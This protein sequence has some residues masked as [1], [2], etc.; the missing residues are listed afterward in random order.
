MNLKCFK[1]WRTFVNNNKWISFQWT[2]DLLSV[3]IVKMFEINCETLSLASAPAPAPDEL[4]RRWGGN[5]CM[6]A[7]P[8]TTAQYNSCSCVT[9]HITSQLDLMLKLCRLSYKLSFIK[10][11]DKKDSHFYDCHRWEKSYFIVLIF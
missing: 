6:A 5:I 8:R 3:K 7:S 2:V 4:C 1:L 9:G 10:K 11:S